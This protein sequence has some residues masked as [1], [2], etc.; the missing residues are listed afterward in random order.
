M[1]TKRKDRREKKSER[2]EHVEKKKKG[3]NE[4]KTQ[5]RRG[6]GMMSSYTSFPHWSEITNKNDK[7]NKQSRQ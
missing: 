4:K 6:E 5:K 2:V 3:H 7:E 1:K